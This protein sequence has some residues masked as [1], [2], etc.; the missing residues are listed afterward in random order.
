MMN[1]ILAID[2]L[3]VASAVGAMRAVFYEL[4]CYAGDGIDHP[5]CAGKVRTFSD[6]FHLLPAFILGRIFLTGKWTQQKKMRKQG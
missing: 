5:L 4:R 3:D 6:V 1:R 2:G